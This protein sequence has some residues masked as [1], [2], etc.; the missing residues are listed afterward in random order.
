MFILCVVCFHFSL[1]VCDG[2]IVH[3]KQK[4]HAWLDFQT[5]RE[6]VRDFLAVLLNRFWMERKWPS[7]KMSVRSE[8]NSSPSRRKLE[9]FPKGIAVLPGKDFLFLSGSGATRLS[10]FLIHCSEIPNALQ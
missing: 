6:E 3:V 10:P 2:L 8:E 4:L 7:G 5:G 9:S 1:F